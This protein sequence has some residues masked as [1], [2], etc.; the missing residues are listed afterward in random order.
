LCQ[1]G[2]NKEDAILILESA[3]GLASK[4]D[5]PG[6]VEGN[7]QLQITSAMNFIDEIIQP[8][9]AIYVS[10]TSTHRGRKFSSFNVAIVSL[11]LNLMN[12]FVHSGSSRKLLLASRQFSD[13]FDGILTLHKAIKIHGAVLLIEMCLVMHV[14]YQAVMTRVTI[15]RGVTALNKLP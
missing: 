2:F 7:F 4:G 6:L 12:D 1:H 8:Q 13:S 11:H 9:Y 10:I 14:W 3:K 5:T 15:N